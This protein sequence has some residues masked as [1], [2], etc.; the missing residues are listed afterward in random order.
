MTAAIY[1]QKG[2]S[3]DYTPV[4]AVAGGAVVVIGDLVGIA[5]RDIPANTT[6]SVALEGVYKI[7]KA[8][9][10]GTAIGAGVK[11]YWD[12]AAGVA[13]LSGVS[14][15]MIGYSIVAAGTTDDAVEVK[16]ARGAPTAA[17]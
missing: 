6:G 10:A 16:L 1:R 8:T 14:L 7:P 13:K 2:E 5:P 12:A 11:V 9:G 17:T 15:P 3:I 4:S